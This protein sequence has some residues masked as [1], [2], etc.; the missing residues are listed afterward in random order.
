MTSDIQ[1]FQFE[2]GRWSDETFGAQR[3]PEGKLAH[4]LKEVKELIDAP[5][6]RS[7]YADC[8]TLLLDAGRKAGYMADDI[9]DE[10]WDKLQKN[11]HRNWGAPNADGSVEHVRKEESCLCISSGMARQG[12]AHIDCPFHGED[13]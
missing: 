7:E 6:D 2:H 12:K 13:S 9:V 8:L 11:R 5:L 10:A 3:G 1:R 4:L